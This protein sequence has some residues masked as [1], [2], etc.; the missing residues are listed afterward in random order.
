MLLGDAEQS[1]HFVSIRNLDVHAEA[2]LLW[3]CMLFSVPVMLCTWK[4]H[5]REVVLS[6]GKL[7]SDKYNV[8]LFLR[9]HAIFQIRKCYR[10]GMV[11][12]ELLYI[13][14]SMEEKVF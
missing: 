9:R 2:E 14:K 6:N 4:R 7:V 8:Q 12:G 3:F 13:F 1:D 11:L 10:H 5:S